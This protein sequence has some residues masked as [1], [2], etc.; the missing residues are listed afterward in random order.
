MQAGWFQ[1]NKGHSGQGQT[2]ICHLSCQMN[3]TGADRVSKCA[4]YFRLTDR[5]GPP[6]RFKP[7][8]LTHMQ[9]TDAPSC[10]VRCFEDCQ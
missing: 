3:T 8:N 10:Y 5:T 1:V 4:H 2:S 6:S 7:Q 9:H